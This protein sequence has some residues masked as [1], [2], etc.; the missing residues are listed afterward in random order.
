LSFAEFNKIINFNLEV[1][2]RNLLGR[3]AMSIGLNPK[4]FDF[5]L[6]DAINSEDPVDVKKAIWRGA[7]VDAK[8]QDNPM[9]PLALASGI[10]GKEAKELCQIL[11]RAGADVDGRNFHNEG[12][13]L[14]SALFTLNLE[15]S[16]EF[17]KNKANIH[18]QDNVGFNPVHYF[19]HKLHATTVENTESLNYELLNQHLDLYEKLFDNSK[20]NITAEFPDGKNLHN[21]LGE[22]VEKMKDHSKSEDQKLVLERLKKLKMQSK[23]TPEGVAIKTILESKLVKSTSKKPSAPLEILPPEMFALVAKTTGAQNP[24]STFDRTQAQIAQQAAALAPDQN[25]GPGPVNQ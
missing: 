10:Q 7:N 1:P 6:F 24:K 14:M 3:V 4:A 16:Q 21:L 20:T 13:P 5:P 19:L 23:L 8:Y 22:L 17:F 11:L 18:A 9:T 12:T 25:L 15:L 2:M